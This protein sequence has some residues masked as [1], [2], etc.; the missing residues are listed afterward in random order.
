[1]GVGPE[2]QA[3]P[4]RHRVLPQRR[5]RRHHHRRRRPVVGIHRDIVLLGIDG[6]APG[7]GLPGHHGGDH[8]ILVGRVDRT[9]TD[10]STLPA[11]S[12]RRGFH[13]LP[14][15][16]TPR[17]MA[18]PSRV[19]FRILWANPRTASPRFRSLAGGMAVAW[20]HC[21]AVVSAHNLGALD[22]L[23]C[24]LADP[25]RRRHAVP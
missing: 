25:V 8:T 24:A 15:T 18:L 9:R 20:P 13:P 7:P 12:F 14:A 16:P 11:L 1:M 3:F 17:H 4:G 10:E 21:D 5:H 23:T 19:A 22:A 2:H 6:S